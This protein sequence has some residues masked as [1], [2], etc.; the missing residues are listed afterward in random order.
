MAGRC[1]VRLPHVIQEVYGR[2]AYR[3]VLSNGS[4]FSAF[5]H[6]NQSGYRMEPSDDT[7]EEAAVRALLYDTLVMAYPLVADN[8]RH[9]LK[10]LLVLLDRKE[11]AAKCLVM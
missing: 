3:W 5:R 1:C 7:P 8:V 6:T 2:I 11:L 10:D 4:A 9:A